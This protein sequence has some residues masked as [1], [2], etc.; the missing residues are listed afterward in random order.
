[1][2][3]DR[4]LLN[5]LYPLIEKGLSKKENT[6]K[7]K[8]AVSQFLDRNNEK[9]TTNGPVYRIIFSEE[10]ANKLYEAI[11]VDPLTIKGIINRSPTIKS[12]WQIMNN[13]FNS[14]IALTIR[15]YKVNKN[16][17]MVNATLIY[18]TMSMYP[19]LHYKY[20]QYEPNE[21]IMNYTINNLSN[22]FK[23]KQTGTI[24]AALVD[25][26]QVSDRTYT[27]D[28]IR[29]TD[30]DIVDYIEAVKTRM[31]SLLRKI[32]NEFYENDKKKN[33]LNTES[34]SFEEDNY[35]EADSNIYAV[36]RVTNNVVLKLI[37]NGP[38]IQLVNIAAKMSQ[39]SV[40][41][42]RNYVNTLVIGENR[43][44]IKTVVECILF[45]YLFDSQNKVEDIGS[46]KFLFYCLE[47]YKKS[48]TTDENII[49]IKKILD[50]WLED[51]GTYKKTQRL[52]T[53][54][55]FRRALFT[56]FVL[57]IQH[58]GNS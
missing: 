54:N 50:E 26:V 55:N 21:N 48:N 14:A 11:E 33:Y 40:S 30:K 24:Y 45:L 23:I 8:L 19:S 37:V 49:K 32:S 25:T 56:F 46:N 15:Y 27:D 51:L 31:N 22:K 36:E 13:P 12:Q 10:D 41:E 39:V 7:L 17:E 35:H 28:L 42:L 53:I 1:M 9:L 34:D 16:P 2:A 43:E 5:E 47:V 58:T 52:A 6:Q 38:N 29:G 20:F 18:L 44:Q 3:N 4:V 57:S